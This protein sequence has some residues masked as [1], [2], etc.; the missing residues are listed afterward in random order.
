MG[1][2]AKKYDDRY[3]DYLA[4]FLNSVGAEDQNIVFA[5]TPATA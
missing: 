2:G 3:L 1:Y 5:P 4:Y